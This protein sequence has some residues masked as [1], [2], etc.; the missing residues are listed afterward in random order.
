M[1]QPHEI[2]RDARDHVARLHRDAAE[3]DALA[4]AQPAADRTHAP[5]FGLHSSVAS[6]LR[7]LAR[8]LEPRPPVRPT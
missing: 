8:R 7:A 3:H 6:L 2:L 1:I 5:G 4:A